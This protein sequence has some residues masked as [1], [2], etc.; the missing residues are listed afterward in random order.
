MKKRIIAVILA[1]VLA[2]GL[3]ASA[4][5]EFRPVPSD[6]GGGPGSLNENNDGNRYDGCYSDVADT[7][8]G[9]INDFFA[10]MKNSMDLSG[11]IR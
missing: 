4:C 11:G 6:V 3:A 1:A 8:I 10:D 9:A 7:F 5:A 2:I